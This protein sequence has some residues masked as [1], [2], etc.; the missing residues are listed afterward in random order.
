MAAPKMTFVSSL[1]KKLLFNLLQVFFNAPHYAEAASY[2]DVNNVSAVF[3]K[4]E[5]HC[6]RRVSE[7]GSLELSHFSWGKQR[8]QYTTPKAL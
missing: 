5:D 3:L 6:R 4:R 7:T 8:L 1:V 2:A